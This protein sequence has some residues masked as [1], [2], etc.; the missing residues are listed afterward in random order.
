M[1]VCWELCAVIAAIIGLILGTYFSQPK[2]Q[3]ILRGVGIGQ[4]FVLPIEPTELNQIE[5]SLPPQ[6]VIPV[7]NV[8]PKS[9]AAKKIDQQETQFN[10][11]FQDEETKLNLKLPEGWDSGEW[12]KPVLASFPDF[13]KTQKA[14]G[15]FDYSTKLH[16]DES[17][18][19][20]T[21]PIEKTIEGA[22]LELHFKLP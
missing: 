10:A 16:W 4:P 13:F 8:L 7:S 18:E 9:S 17:E 11:P 19:A 2:P 5:D 20:R 15:V 21:M 12:K 1:R 3:Q 6:T 22:E 14:E